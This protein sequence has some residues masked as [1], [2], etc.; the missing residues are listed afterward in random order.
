MERKL[1]IKPPE[2]E[3]RSIICR[4]CG[5][6]FVWEKGEQEFFWSKGLA[7]PKRCPDCREKRK[8]TIVHVHPDNGPEGDY[9]TK[10]FD[11]RQPE[12]ND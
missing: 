10:D 4:D 12:V 3:D 1:D 11:S 6:S 8:L 5:E 9:L 7:T 2:F